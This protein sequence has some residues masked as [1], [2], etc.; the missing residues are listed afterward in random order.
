MALGA[1]VNWRRVCVERGMAGLAPIEGSSDRSR[2]TRALVREVAV[3]ETTVELVMAM[4]DDVGEGI[5]SLSLLPTFDTSTFGG[6]LKNTR[7]RVGLRE[8]DVGRLFG[9]D[10]SAVSDWETGACRPR[11]AIE[12]MERI[13]RAVKGKGNRLSPRHP[14]RW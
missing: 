7:I 9:V 11:R 8:M 2:F 12:E 6:R 13:I 14:C 1:R 4:A 5:F 3:H 10:G